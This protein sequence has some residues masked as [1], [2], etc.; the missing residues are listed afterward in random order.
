MVV[1]VLPLL[2]VIPIVIAF[3]NGA[4]NSISEITGIPTSF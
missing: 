3:V 1:V 4:A 2:P